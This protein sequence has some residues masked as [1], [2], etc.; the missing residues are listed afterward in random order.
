[1]AIRSNLSEAQKQFLITRE[2]EKESYISSVRGNDDIKHASALVI[3]K[4]EQTDEFKMQLEIKE[5]QRNRAGEAMR[6]QFG[7]AI[8][9][10][11]VISGEELDAMCVDD[12][13]KSKMYDM[14]SKYKENNAVYV[15]YGTD[16]DPM[17]WAEYSGKGFSAE[18]KPNNISGYTPTGYI[19]KIS[20]SLQ[21]AYSENKYQY[22]REHPTRLIGYTASYCTL[23]NPV[24]VP[25]GCDTDYIYEQTGIS[26]VVLDHDGQVCDHDEPQNPREQLA[27]IK[28]YK[29]IAYES[30]VDSSTPQSVR[31]K[32]TNNAYA[33]DGKK[34]N[35]NLYLA[36]YYMGGSTVDHSLLVDPRYMTELMD[37]SKATINPEKSQIMG[38]TSAPIYETNHMYT[39]SYSTDQKHPKQNDISVQ[40]TNESVSRF[41]RPAPS[42]SMAVLKPHKGCTF[43]INIESPVTKKPNREYGDAEMKLERKLQAV[44]G[45][46]AKKAN[47]TIK[48]KQK[49]MI[50]SVQNKGTNIGM[51][52]EDIESALP[53]N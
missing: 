41:H 51:Q 21:D 6:D 1:M 22:E 25:E 20:N 50:Q 7:T 12:E 16:T 3:Y 19:D 8:Y 17:R 48:S 24:R 44:Y 35:S 15:R 5:L 29:L 42:K 52:Q 26:P 40:Y 14:L 39:K 47:E 9:N 32:V 36:N 53:F 45:E 28:G 46:A 34:L 11:Y 31:A 49:N 27:Y 30:L 43:A 37:K 2:M 18:G 13:S 10:T 23:P 4:D 38:A 33:S